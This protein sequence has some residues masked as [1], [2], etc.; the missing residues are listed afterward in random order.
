MKQSHPQ[1]SQNNIKSFRKRKLE[2][3]KPASKLEAIQQKQQQALEQI[4]RTQST[5]GQDS[6][7]HDASRAQRQSIAEDIQGTMLDIHTDTQQVSEKNHQDTLSVIQDSVLTGAELQAEATTEATTEVVNSVSQAAS[8]IVSAITEQSQSDQD[9]QIN[10][11]NLLQELQKPST[12]DSFKEFPE[13]NRFLESLISE[14][15]GRESSEPDLQPQILPVST[16][17]VPDS[18]PEINTPE[19][20]GFDKKALGL[21]QGI[22]EQTSNSAASLLTLITGLSM[23]FLKI[24]G[25]LTLGLFTLITLEKVLRKLWKDYGQAITDFWEGMKEGASRLWDG[26][27]DIWTATGLDKVWD[28][29]TSLVADI[30][31]GQFLH[32]FGNYLMVIGNVLSDNL[33]KIGEAIVRAIPFSESKADEMEHSRLRSK[34][35][36]GTITDKESERY[37][38]LQEKFQESKNE[39]AS[40]IQTRDITIARELQK[41]HDVSQMKATQEQ[42]K[43]GQ[44]DVNGLYKGSEAYKEAEALIIQQNPEL[45]DPKKYAS[46]AEIIADAAV[47]NLAVAVRNSL[48]SPSAGDTRTV[49]NA[50]EEIQNL[51]L[52]SAQQTEV[53]NLISK[54]KKPSA[55]P[56][57]TVTDDV[58]NQQAKATELNSKS[59]S[60]VSN[61]QN[62]AV[63]NT[64]NNKQDT[65]IFSAP[66]RG[67]ASISY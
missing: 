7:N 18:T 62:T 39:R 64:T 51:Q 2:D 11:K 31:D 17:K 34:I 25:I 5:A 37:L 12:E 50:L 29:F 32:G 19:S 58:K 40:R 36:T 3:N 13:A 59:E 66:S 67:P 6:R 54:I 22:K 46:K 14:S 38:E 61:T 15:K 9:A 57:A 28:A 43:A 53:N 49:N 63:V 27:K 35:G 26:V 4:A 45:K 30:A 20:Q 48:E 44:A 56:V 41:T 10:P 23:A 24:T 60:K 21:L 33:S 65:Q 16:A 55:A 47:N 1:Q 52:N 42:K 8:E